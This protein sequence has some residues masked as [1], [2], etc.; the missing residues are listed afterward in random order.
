MVPSEFRRHSLCLKYTEFLQKSMK[1]VSIA[2]FLNPYRAYG[3]AFSPL[4]SSSSR[5]SLFLAYLIRLYRFR[6]ETFDTFLEIIIL[7]LRQPD[8]NCKYY[9]STVLIWI[10]V[11]VDQT[12]SH[13]LDIKIRKE[14]EYGILC[15]NYARVGT[16]SRTVKV[17]VNPE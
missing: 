4:P 6:K 12:K 7:F 14:E 11:I 5:P 3:S 10:I 9:Y 8:E 15:R 2:C 16:L 1:I 17:P 13:H